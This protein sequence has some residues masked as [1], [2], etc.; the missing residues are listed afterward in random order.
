MFDILGA[1]PYLLG[2]GLLGRQRA[3]LLVQGVDD[4]PVAA[5]LLGHVFVFLHQSLGGELVVADVGARHDPQHVQ[6]PGVDVVSVGLQGGAT[7]TEDI[8]GHF[9]LY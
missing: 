3:G 5:D 2:V 6:H 8:L 4:G 9:L 7:D 1:L